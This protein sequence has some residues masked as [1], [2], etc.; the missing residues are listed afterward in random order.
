MARLMQCLCYEMRCNIAGQHT[1]FDH[2]GISNAEVSARTHFRFSSTSERRPQGV[3]IEHAFLPAALPRIHRFG[4][5]FPSIHAFQVCSLL[6]HINKKARLGC[7]PWSLRRVAP[8]SRS[9]GG[10][11][12]PQDAKN[13]ISFAQLCTLQA[14][15][16]A[17][18]H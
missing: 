8:V 12:C 10:R 17:T 14:R 11:G 3:V 9:E 4:Q 18:Y 1:N 16:A 7:G 6:K 2:L 13:V 15:P 5:R